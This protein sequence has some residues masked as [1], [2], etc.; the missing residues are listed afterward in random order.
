MKKM[1]VA[2]L[3]LALC[4]VAAQAAITYSGTE[5]TGGPIGTYTVGLAGAGTTAPTLTGSYDVFKITFANASGVIGGF[6]L[7]ITGGLQIGKKNPVYDGDDNVIGYTY[8]QTATMADGNALT[9]SSTK[10]WRTADTHF[11]IPATPVAVVPQQEA[12]DM[13]LGTWTSFLTFDWATGVGN[14]RAA[15]SLE[16]A[17]RLPSVTLFQI[18]L[19]HDTVATGHVTGAVTDGD[20]VKTFMDF[21]VD[22][23][24]P[25]TMTLLGLGGLALIRRRRS[26]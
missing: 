19:P 12:S 7:T 4:T 18:A 10:L 16:L 23:P 2:T 8:G 9:N 25:A 21:Y 1:L 26:A 24:E 20:G 5:T 17:D 22:V 13:A 14:L 3:V 6:D 11:L 15:A